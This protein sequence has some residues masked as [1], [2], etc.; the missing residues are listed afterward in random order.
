L[1][2]D[3]ALSRR[4][5]STV[6]GDKFRRSDSLRHWFTASDVTHA[7][8]PKMKKIRINAPYGGEDIAHAQGLIEL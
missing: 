5:R 7:V 1:S 6:A 2:L 4:N 8:A 3:G